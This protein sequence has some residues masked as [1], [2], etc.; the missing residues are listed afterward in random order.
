MMAAVT[1]LA[2]ALPTTCST[3]DPD[4]DVTPHN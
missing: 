3:R 2:L 4:R 1:A